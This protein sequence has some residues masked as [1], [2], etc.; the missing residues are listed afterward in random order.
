MSYAV[1]EISGVVKNIILKC[2]SMEYILSCVMTIF[3]N[4]VIYYFRL[5]VRLYLSARHPMS[6][7]MVYLRP[8]KTLPESLCILL[9][10]LSFF[11]ELDQL[12]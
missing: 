3:G 12:N 4:E 6:V 1:N 8:W 11:K 2:H 10:E 7:S 5:K 9:N